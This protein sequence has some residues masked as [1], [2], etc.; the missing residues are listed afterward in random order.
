[1][2][3]YNKMINRK[4]TQNEQEYKKRKAAHKMFWQNKRVLFKSK[5]E[6]MEFAYNN[7]EANKIDQQVNII[8]RE[9]KFINMWIL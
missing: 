3:A 8:R 1:M 5:L 2:R 6:Q 4:S 9:F 7:N